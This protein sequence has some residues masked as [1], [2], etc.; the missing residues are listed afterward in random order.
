MLKTLFKSLKQYKKDTIKTPI[1]VS[2][3]V[4]MEVIIPLF[5]ANLIDFGI[6]AGNMQVILQMGFALL[7]ASF[8]SLL[9]GVLAGKSAA[10]SSAGLARN[11]RQD[12]FYN[13]Q[14]FSFWNIDKF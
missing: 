10:V 11:L 5:M 13:V 2:L 3:E 12:M 8:I 6:D 9:F 1:Y 14:K 7:V 4:V